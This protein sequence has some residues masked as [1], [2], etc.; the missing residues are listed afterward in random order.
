MSRRPLLAALG[1]IVGIG[2]VGGVIYEGGHR[3][4]RNGDKGPYGDLLAGLED[5]DE[6]ARVGRAVLGEMPEFRAASV[7]GRLRSAMDGQPLQAVLM[8]DVSTGQV[9]EVENW[10]LP[11]T[12][13]MLCGLAASQ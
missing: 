8:Q 4:F 9:K 10:V 2:L 1:S 12:L 11:N 3:L 7:A 5:R 13:V 6:A